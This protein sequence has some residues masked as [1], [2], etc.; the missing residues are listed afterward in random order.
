MVTITNAGEQ[1][2]NMVSSSIPELAMAIEQAAL[3]RKAGLD[4][5]HRVDG[6]RAMERPIGDDRGCR[7]NLLRQRTLADGRR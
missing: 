3:A 5:A 4:R 1:T 6:S 2:R 7:Q